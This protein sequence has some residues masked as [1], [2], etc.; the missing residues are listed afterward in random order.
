MKFHL[1]YTHWDSS[2]KGFAVAW[3]KRQQMLKSVGF[4]GA[5]AE[6]AEERAKLLKCLPPMLD[7]DGRFYPRDFV[8]IG[9]E[10]V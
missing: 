4:E 5:R 1:E 6:A 3:S 2:K 10:E 8:L 9:R 7:E